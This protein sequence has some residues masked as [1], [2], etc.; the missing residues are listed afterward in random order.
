MLTPSHN[1]LR[2]LAEHDAQAMEAATRAMEEVSKRIEAS[3]V[4]VASSV[5]SSMSNLSSVMNVSTKFDETPPCKRPA[6][7]DDERFLAHMGM[8]SAHIKMT[9][10]SEFLFKLEYS[11]R[12]NTIMIMRKASVSMVSSSSTIVSIVIHWF[13]LTAVGQ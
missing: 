9:N 13:N 11:H 2:S 3:R 7:L 4:G 1:H 8:H 10:Q 6:M 5:M 12:Y